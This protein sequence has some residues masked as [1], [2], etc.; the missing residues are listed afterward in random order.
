MW[1]CIKQ[2]SLQILCIQFFWDIVSCLRFDNTDE[3]SLWMSRSEKVIGLASHLFS[4]GAE[5][6]VFGKKEILWHAHLSS[7]FLLA[8]LSAILI[9]PRYQLAGAQ[10]ALPVSLWPLHFIFQ[11]SIKLI[12]AQKN[13]LKPKFS[14]D[15]WPRCWNICKNIYFLFFLLIG[16]WTQ[17]LRYF[18]VCYRP[19][20]CIW[21]PFKSCVPSIF[22]ATCLIWVRVKGN[23]FLV[24]QQHWLAWTCAVKTVGGGGTR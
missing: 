10:G 2:S 9:F 21:N 5:W 20:L 23:L 18:F 14:A 19:Y 3:L 6:L 13:I 4:C 12:T 8:D 7:S 15:F 1:K 17:M 22:N 16:L 11:Q 24:M